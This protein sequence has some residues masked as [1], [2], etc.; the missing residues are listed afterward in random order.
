MAKGTGTTRSGSAANPTGVGT[1][2]MAAN[3]G[4]GGGGYQPLSKSYKTFDTEYDSYKLLDNYYHRL[5]I[6]KKQEKYLAEY[7][8]KAANSVMKKKVYE[9]YVESTKKTIQNVKNDNK[10]ILHILEKRGVNED[11]IKEH[12]GKYRYDAQ[13][14]AFNKKILK[15]YG[16]DLS[17]IK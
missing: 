11:I 1:Q 5:E 9:G 12:G 2:S 14:K 7:E 17:K 15:K 10:D 16:V 4:G 3:I 6:I 8:K 13:E